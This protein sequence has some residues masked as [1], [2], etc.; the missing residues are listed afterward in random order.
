MSIGKYVELVKASVESESLNFYAVIIDAVFPY[1]SFND[2]YIC[3]LKIVDPSLFIK[4]QIGSED[5]C[6]YATVVL[7]SRKFENLPIITRVGDIIRIQRATL[8]FCDN[9]IRQF[10]VNIIYNSSW[11]IFRSDCN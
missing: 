7:Y 2:K 5:S 10:N 9:D 4:S 3:S 1:K 6:D 8:R 11:A